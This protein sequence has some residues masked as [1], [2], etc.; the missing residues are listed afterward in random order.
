MVRSA[1]GLLVE[2]TEL[3]HEPVEAVLVLWRDVALGVGH[4]AGLGELRLGLL[5]ERAGRVAGLFATGPAARKS[6]DA[7][8]VHQAHGV[9]RRGEEDEGGEDADAARDAQVQ[10]AA[11]RRTRRPRRTLGSAGRGS[12]LGAR[13]GL[14]GE[15]GRL[16]L[17]AITRT[18]AGRGRR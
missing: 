1:L 11:V 4:A 10:R 5:H 17:P 14:L 2:V 16:P 3:A 12:M 6:R 7:G 13:L 18:Q 8:E 9:Q 15:Y